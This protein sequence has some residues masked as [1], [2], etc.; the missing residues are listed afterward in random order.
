MITKTIAALKAAGHLVRVN[1]P[2]RPGPDI[3]YLV[4]GKE[5]PI[6]RVTLA[7]QVQ[8]EQGTETRPIDHVDTD[9]RAQ[10]V[11]HHDEEVFHTIGGE[12]VVVVKTGS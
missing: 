9:D 5:I 6:N 8:T 10:P 1:C 4:D 7:M 12:T 3:V 11:L 2:V